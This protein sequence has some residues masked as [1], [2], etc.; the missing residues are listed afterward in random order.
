MLSGG[1]PDRIRTCDPQIRKRAQCIE[2]V[3]NF[4]KT[5]SFAPKRYQYLSSAF[6]NC[7]ARKFCGV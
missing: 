7:S 3:R 5:G 6:A 4:C 2:L 1:D